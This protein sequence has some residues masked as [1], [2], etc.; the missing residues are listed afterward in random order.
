MSH[1]TKYVE[2]SIT[3]LSTEDIIKIYLEVYPETTEENKG[4]IMSKLNLTWSF[5][6]GYIEDENGY[7][8]VFVPATS[9]TLIIKQNSEKTNKEN[10]L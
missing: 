5:D 6:N 3:K 2:S 7:I 9:N 1:I 10:E 8:L 4:N